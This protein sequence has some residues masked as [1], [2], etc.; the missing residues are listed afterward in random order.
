MD[1]TPIIEAIQT[2]GVAEWLRTSLKALPVINAVHVLGVGLLFGTIIIVDLRLVGYP[3]TTRSVHRTTSE[4]LPFTWA[5]FGLA[6]LSGAAMFSVNATTYMQNTAFF[7]K[8]GIIGLAGINMLVF[9]GLI[10]RGAAAWDTGP[11]IRAAR[12]AGGLS[13][14]FWTLVIVFGRMI[15]FTKGYDFDVP[16]EIEMDFDFSMQIIDYSI[17]RYA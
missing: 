8:M 3:N 10:A 11:T 17:N 9:E 7:L 2:S 15:G 14:V 12:L 1:L 13:I 6:L 5:G 16:E 4:L